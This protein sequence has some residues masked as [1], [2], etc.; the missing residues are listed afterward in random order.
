MGDDSGSYTCPNHRA[1]GIRCTIELGVTITDAAV[2]DEQ[3]TI[4]CAPVRARC[5]AIEERRG[6]FLRDA[7][8]AS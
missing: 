1:E 2:D 3:T 6:V 4:F 5:V 7:G 8:R